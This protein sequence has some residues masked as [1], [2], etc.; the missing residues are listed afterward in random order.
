M[1]KIL[2]SLFFVMFSFQVSAASTPVVD[3]DSVVFFNE[4][5][6]FETDHK[7]AL[8]SNRG[9]TEMK[10][11]VAFH[12]QTAGSVSGFGLQLLKAGTVIKELIENTSG[13]F[14]MVLATASNY[15]VRFLGTDGLAGSATLSASAVPVPAAVWLFGSA[16]MGLFGASRRKSSAIAA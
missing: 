12:D 5:S 3:E 10:L 1:K 16:L 13:S 4:E 14:S 2:V 6:P 9:L 8:K 7:F 11:D 15:S